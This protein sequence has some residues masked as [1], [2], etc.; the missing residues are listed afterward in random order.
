MSPQF[1]FA[2]SS[3]FTAEPLEPVFRFWADE[4]RR[5]YDVAFAPYNQLVQ[6]VYDPGGVFAGNQ[7]GVNIVLVRADDFGTDRREEN[8]R[9]IVRHLR[10]GAQNLSQPLVVC[11]CPSSPGTDGMFLTDIIAAELS[12]QPNIH[13]ITTAEIHRLYPVANWYSQQ[14]ERLGQVP[15]TE[16][17]FAALGTMLVRKAD[18]LSRTPFKVIALDCDNTLWSGVCGEDGPRGVFVEPDRKEMQEFFRRQRDAGMLLAMASKN[19]EDDVIETFRQNPEMPLRL[20]DF[21][22]RRVNWESKASNIRALAAELNLGI[23]SFIFVD[24]DAKECAEVSTILPDV[25]TLAL[26][27]DVD[28]I[29]HFLSHVWAFDHGVLTEADRKRAESYQQTR[30]FSQ[31]LERAGSLEQFLAELNLRVAIVPLESSRQPRTA[32]LTQR[33]NQF[34]ATTIRRRE[35]DLQDLIESGTE[36]WTIDVADRFGD[37]GQTGVIIFREKDDA[38][39]VD[40]FLLSCRVLGR[41][42]E[43]EI[44]RRL[45]AEALKRGRSNIVINFEPSAKNQIVRNFLTATGKES[46]SAFVFDT[47]SAVNLAWKADSLPASSSAPSAP[48]APPTERSDYLHIARTYS[49]A[50]QIVNAIRRGSRILDEHDLTETERKLAQ[51]WVGLLNAPSVRRDDNFFDLGGHSL[52]VV[53][54]QMRIKE[55][56]GIELDVDEIYSGTLT[57]EGLASRID[58]QQGS[59][60]SAEEYAQILAE[61]DALSDEEVRELLAREEARS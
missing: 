10:A 59:G 49:H 6:T 61:I 53:L 2:I 50:D 4:L 21:A 19:N 30:E 54:L 16:E 26:P 22:A 33:T 29:P 43:Y 58:I 56:F 42:V 18:A 41:G 5:S 28:L 32:Q 37:H 38:L 11:E 27:H 15:Y 46:D 20:D 51:I 31:A 48:S 25:L 12:T 8:A 24:D 44:V 45:A 57:L 40:T 52:L 36:C 47:A 60:L 9:D 7:P 13:T 23:D 14:G 35:R 17:F 39:E 55:A 1:R 34:N 3:T